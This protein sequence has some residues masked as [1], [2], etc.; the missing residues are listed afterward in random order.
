VLD[1]FGRI[2]ILV[3][4]AGVVSRIGEW[5]LTPEEWDRVHAVN[6][7]ATFFVSRDAAKSMRDSGGGAILNVSSIAGQHGGIA[8]SPA[9]ASS[10]AAVIGLTRSLARRFAPHKVRVNC[11]APADIETDMTATWPQELRDKLN[12]LTPLNRFGTVDEVTEAATFLVSDHASYI[13][14]QT[15][16]ING[17]AYFS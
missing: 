10:K 4:N 3:N 12:S 6:L 7:R 11:I 16:S 13:T 2:D 8:G 14:G 5:D 1:R 15:L 17:G 9:Y